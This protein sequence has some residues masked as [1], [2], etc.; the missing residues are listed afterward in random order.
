MS[1]FRLFIIKFVRALLFCNIVIDS[2]TIYI[3]YFFTYV[4]HVLI[5]AVRQSLAI[6]RAACRI[7]GVPRLFLL[8]LGL[9]E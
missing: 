8:D 2:L 6:A 3:Y 7:W 4:L 9:T 5:L 1:V